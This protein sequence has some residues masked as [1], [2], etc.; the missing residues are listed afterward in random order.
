MSPEL[1]LVTA[2]QAAKMLG[3]QTV[4]IRQWARRYN[5]RQ[6]DPA[7]YGMPGER[8]KRYDYNDLA[9]IDGCLNR[10]EKPG[11]TPEKRDQLREDLRTRWAA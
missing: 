4:T 6:Y 11:K 1:E 8:A 10:G 5:A 9:T 7:E 3:R 2:A